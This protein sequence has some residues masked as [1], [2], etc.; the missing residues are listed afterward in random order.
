M[1]IQQ[2]KQKISHIF[3][4]IAYNYDF[5]NHFLSF[6]MDKYWRR[7]MVAQIQ[8][9]EDAYILDAACGTGDVAFEAIKQGY[10]HIVGI[11]ISRGMLDIAE[12]KSVL[13]KC[14]EQVKFKNADT[15]SI[16]FDSSSFDAVTVAFGIRNFQNLNMGL[17]E[18][19]RV[20]KSNGRCI[21]LEFSM[22][23]KTIFSF[24]YRFYFVKI[25]P[26][27]GY[28]F[29]GDKEAYSYLSQ[30]VQEF[31]SKEKLIKILSDA[32]LKKITSL[33]LT[34]GIAYIYIAMK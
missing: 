26:W 32:G 13:K 6:N 19:Y 18:I 22:P 9:K 31:P 15:H 30:S 34:G 7:K 2:E 29:S 21:I 10:K 27:I 11:D 14:Q 3:N 12:R 16:P 28:L 17:Q 33:R 24:L 23:E 5:L 20:L 25:L 4:R 1:N 8:Q